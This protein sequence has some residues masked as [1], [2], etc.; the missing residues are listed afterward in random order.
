MTPRLILSVVEHLKSS[1]FGCMRSA[2]LG[3]RNPLPQLQPLA[4]PISVEAQWA[5][6]IGILKTTIGRASS[7]QEL[8]TA[9]GLQLDAAT[10][11]LHGLLAELA[12]IMPILRAREAQVVGRIGPHI[13]REDRAVLAA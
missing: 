13:P 3:R 7:V 12:D 4:A 6:S 9:A 2:F 5:R 1:T 8:Q 11:S 10:Y